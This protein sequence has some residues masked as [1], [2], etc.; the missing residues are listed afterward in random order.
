MPA[1][2]ASQRAA[3]GLCERC[4]KPAEVHVTWANGVRSGTELLCGR[5]WDEQAEQDREGQS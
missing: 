3:R 1:W 2:I 4:G 5:C